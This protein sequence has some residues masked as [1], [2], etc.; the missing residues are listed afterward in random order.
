[1][2]LVG[3]EPTAPNTFEFFAT[4]ERLPDEM[5]PDERKVV[6]LD[7]LSEALGSSNDKAGTPIR[8]AVPATVP[9]TLSLREKRLIELKR[10]TITEARALV[11]RAFRR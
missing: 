10:K 2:K 5:P 1:M 9:M 6:C 3:F 8:P 11:R 7:S 4:L